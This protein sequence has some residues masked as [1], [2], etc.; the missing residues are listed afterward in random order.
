MVLAGARLAISAP[1]LIFKS[2]TGCLN[3]FYSILTFLVTP[4]HPLIL[5]LK[6]YSIDLKLRSVSGSKDSISEK[7]DGARQSLLDQSIELQYHLCSHVKLELGLETIFQLCIKLILLAYS[8]SKTRTT[9]GLSTMFEKDFLLGETVDFLN[10]II[11]IFLHTSTYWNFVSNVNSHIQGL[12]S[13]R[14]RF[15]FASKLAAG[16]H[17]FFA[18]TTRI[19]A[20]IIFFT[21]SL[22]LLDTLRHWQGEQFQWH[23]A[24]INEFVTNKSLYFPENSISILLNSSSIFK[25]GS[26]FGSNGLYLSNQFDADLKD[27]VPEN[28]HTKEFH[29]L[30]DIQFGNSSSMSWK[31]L[32]RC[33]YNMSDISRVILPDYTLYTLL[34]LKQYFCLFVGIMFTQILVIFLVKLKLAKEFSKFNLLDK[35]IHCVECSNL[36]YNV[37]EWDSPRCCDAVEHIKRMKSNQWE[38]FVLIF[39][40]LVFKLMMLCPLYILGKLD[41]L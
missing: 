2:A 23:P 10:V 14:R 27:V 29:I 1:Q 26:L 32:D 3:I 34:S 25:T 19:L 11:L 9:E 4:F 36:A 21:P 18:T 39:V 13:K 31:Q 12:S 33:T 35:I 38:G 37:E 28:L 20:I 5:S 30:G 40:N 24:I 22:G 16:F 41:N 17:A 15:P 8:K 6:Q 7:T